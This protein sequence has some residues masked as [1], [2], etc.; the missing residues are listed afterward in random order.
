MP[1]DR[2]PPQ[3][4]EAEE[5]VLGS[6]LLDPTCIVQIADFLR[7]GD[8]YR[9]KNNWVYEADVALYDRRNVID[10]VTLCDE[11]E[12]QGHLADVGGSAYISTLMN[13]VPTAAHVEHYAHIVERCATL[14]RLITAGTGIV[15]LGYQEDADPA[16]ALDKAEQLIFAVAERRLSRDFVTLREALRDYF[17]QIDTLHAHHGKLVGVPTGF[18]DLDDLLG[19]LHNSDLIIVAGRPSAGKTSFAT[20]IAQHIA[21]SEKKPVALFS[22]EMSVEQLVQR[23]LCSE[24]NVDSQRLRGGF[25]DDDEWQRITEAMGTL[26]DAPMFI[27]DSA[28]I[29]AMELRTKAR[30]LKAEHDIGAVFIDY[31]QLMQVSEIARSLKGLARELNVPVVALSQLS[32]AVES[33]NPHTPILSDLRESGSIEQDADVVMFVH[34]E[35][36]YDQNTEKKNIAD[37]IVAKHRNGPIGTIPLRWF[38]S[39]TRFADLA[40]QPADG[41][42]EPDA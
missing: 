40:V 23:L 28:N 39:Q 7:P 20:T 6:L 34:R 27:D 35:E 22:L 42:Y 30:R 8:F 25:I 9:E 21:V 38:G 3:N 41:S 19:G 37:I 29:T 18:H 2:L 11:L 1:E 16:I 36:M 5:A 15:R 12:R 31:L 13:A 10:V 4:I 14:R 33:R 32:R 24:A 26:S 17:D